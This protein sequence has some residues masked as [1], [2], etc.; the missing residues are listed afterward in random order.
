MKS[1][2]FLEQYV[3]YDE[4][5]PSCLRWKRDIHTKPNNRG[6]INVYKDSVAGA[7]AKNYNKHNGAWNLSINGS[8]LKVHRVIYQLFNDD[9]ADHDIID[10]ING[11]PSDN[12]IENLRKV[13]H[14]ENMRNRRLSINNKTGVNGIEFYDRPHRSPYFVV[15]YRINGKQKRNSFAVSTYGYEG[16]FMA[17][18]ARRIEI[19]EMLVSQYNYT[20]RHGRS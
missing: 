4:S 16:A 7:W 17:A 6:K 3:Y 10:H 13:T 9:L 20:E 5:S 11:T 12:R 8:K 18:I 19:N 2:N 15:G 14:V 1:K